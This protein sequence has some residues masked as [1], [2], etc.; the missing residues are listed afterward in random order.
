MIRVAL[1]G[2]LG[3]KLRAVL[4]ALA[5]VLGVAMIS[6]TLVLT[7]AIDRAFDQIFVQSYAGTDAVVTAAESNISFEGES[8]TVPPFPEGVLNEVRGVDSVDAAAGSVFEETA[9]KILDR[10][11]EPIVKNA[12]TFGFGLDTTYARFNP[13]ELKE[14]RWANGPDEVVI[15]SGTAEDESYGV[16][17]RVGI[18]T[19]APLRDFEVVGVAQYPGVESIGGATFAVFDVRTAQ[20]L[21]DK[22]GQARRRLRGGREHRDPRPARARPGAGAPRHGAGAHRV[23]AGGG[24]VV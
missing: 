10:E 22:V 11:G 20:Q 14:G 12:P 5:I 6:G 24:G 18:A 3:R 17:D 2:L 23:R 21:L 9:V 7:D 15:D 8:A 19:Y 4:T 1:R 13:L 16:G